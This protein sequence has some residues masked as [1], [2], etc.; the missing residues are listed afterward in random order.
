ML[1]PIVKIHGGK[2][3]L[4]HWIIENFP[5]DY[6]RYTYV[7]PYIGGGSVFLN[8]TASQLEVINDLNKNLIAIYRSLQ[9]D[10]AKFIDTLKSI[11][12]NNETFEYYTNN[13]GP[14]I[15]VREYVLFRM[16][17]GGLRK[18][19]AWSERLRG[20]K[21]GDVNAWETAIAELPQIAKR[22]E[23]V[24][25]RNACATNVICAYDNP[26]TIFYLDPPYLPDT[27]VSKVAYGNYEMTY[28][29]HDGLLNVIKQCRGKVLISGYDNTLYNAELSNWNK[30]TKEIVNNSG[31]TK[32]KS[33]RLEVLWRNY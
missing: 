32:K 1:R 11:P 27:R 6:T 5:A 30:I 12:Y 4:K 9:I 22:L 21:P 24:V 17:R 2:H 25:I 7:E 13:Y 18:S 3:Y 31:Q 19:F 14:D 10:P 28:R 8:K 23:N 26:N 29:D 33:R 16:S 20:G 15:G